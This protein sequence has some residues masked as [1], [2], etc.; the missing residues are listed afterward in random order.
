MPALIAIPEL[1]ALAAAGLVFGYG[2][3]VALRRSID[4][5]AARRAWLPSLLWTLVRIAAAVLFFLVVARRGADGLGPTARPWS[6]LP[7]LAAF[8]GFLVARQL[9]LRSTRRA[10]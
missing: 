7:V 8:A 9:A 2:Y 1:A 10:L 5:Y 3:F 4:M 6:A